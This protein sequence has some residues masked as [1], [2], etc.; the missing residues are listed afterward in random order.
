M[1]AVRIRLAQ[2]FAGHRSFGAIF[3]ASNQFAAYANQLLCVAMLVLCTTMYCKSFREV[4]DRKFLLNLIAHW[5]AGVYTNIFFL[6]YKE[7][8]YICCFFYR[9]GFVC[10]NVVAVSE[11]D[12]E[13]ENFRGLL[14]KLARKTRG[15]LWNKE[16][17]NFCETY[18]H[19][20]EAGLKETRIC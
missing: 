11:T 18:A 14:A 20:E 3:A 10:T 17:K 1:T 8:K 12:F 9:R 6:K 16:K 13:W 19:I 7:F 5:A 2:M 15:W 4:R